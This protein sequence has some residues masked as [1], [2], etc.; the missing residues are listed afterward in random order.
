MGVK[1][2]CQIPE[3]SPSVH[4]LWLTDMNTSVSLQAALSV[5]IIFLTPYYSQTITSRK[6]WLN[7]RYTSFTNIL[8]KENSSN[9]V[10]LQFEYYVLFPFSYNGFVTQILRRSVK[11][12]YCVSLISPVPTPR[13]QA[14]RHGNFK[15]TQRN[16]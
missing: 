6:C 4:F 8:Q 2:L 1:I 9:K 13:T 15:Y 11:V 12:W 7:L 16:K 14:A 5:E 10:G 3:N